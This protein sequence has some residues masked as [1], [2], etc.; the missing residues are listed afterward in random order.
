MA[1]DGSD[2]ADSVVPGGHAAYA[3]LLHP[4]GDD[5]D[6]TV[7]W[8]DVAAWSGLAL[9]R[10]AQFHDIAL[11]RHA[12]PT[13]APWAGPGPSKG[14][15]TAADATTLAG[16]LRAHTSTPQTCWFCLWDGYGVDRELAVT[17]MDEKNAF[18]PSREATDRELLDAATSRADEPGLSEWWGWW[19]AK[20]VDPIPPSVRAGR[21]VHLPGGRDCLLHTGPI[22]DALAF[23]D[24]PVQTPTL[25][26]PT[27]PGAWQATSIC[28]G[29]IWP[30]PTS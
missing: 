5:D 11:P 25:W 6:Q 8:A 2:R 24:G 15:L 28:P 29:P 3:R 7:R 21:R 9:A 23:T 19:A 13:P 1:P 16:L 27:G 14:T 18:D 30:A 17:P 12:P 22:E 26:W 4:V 20:P 10:L